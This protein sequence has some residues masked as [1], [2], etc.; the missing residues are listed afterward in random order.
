[1]T[2]RAARPRRGRPPKSPGDPLEPRSLALP[3]SQWKAL[4]AIAERLSRERKERVTA[5]DVARALLAE[6]I[7]GVQPR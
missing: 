6:R 2:R 7:A 5:A 4:G 1:M 3:R